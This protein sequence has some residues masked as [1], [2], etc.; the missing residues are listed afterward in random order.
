MERE[1]PKYL[2]QVQKQTAMTGEVVTISGNCSDDGDLRAELTR[3]TDAID[4]RMEAVNETIKKA[5]GGRYSLHDM[6]TA[7]QLGIPV[8]ELVEKNRKDN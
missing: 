8:D 2:I 5:T 3:I 6:D 7:M 1:I 4:H